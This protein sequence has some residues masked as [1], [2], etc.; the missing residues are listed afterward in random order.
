MMAPR[1]AEI[2]NGANMASRI[3]SVPYCIK[4]STLFIKCVTITSA[5]MCII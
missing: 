1:T 5:A 3:A 2:K 4:I